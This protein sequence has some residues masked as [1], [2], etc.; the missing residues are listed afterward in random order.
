MSIRGIKIALILIAICVVAPHPKTIAE[1][2]GTEATTEGNE[3]NGECT[4][5]ALSKM[6]RDSAASDRPRA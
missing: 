1:E 3:G 5:E 6:R 4:L 2:R